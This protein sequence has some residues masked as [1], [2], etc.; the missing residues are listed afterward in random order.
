MNYGTRYGNREPR[1]PLADLAPTPSIEVRE[2]KLVR[3][4]VLR[5]FCVGGIRREPGEMVE[6][7]EFAAMTLRALGRAEPV[8]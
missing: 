1:N 3:V 2:G 7:R 5:A 6:L 4:R 8:S